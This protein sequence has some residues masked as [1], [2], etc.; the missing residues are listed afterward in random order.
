MI[1]VLTGIFGTDKLALAEDIVQDSIIEAISQW[2]YNGIPKQPIGWLYKVAKNKTLN[3]LKR[4]KYQEK[5]ISEV[6][7]N[8]NVQ[9]NFAKDSSAFFTDESISDDQLRMMFMCCHSAISNDSQ[10]ALILKTLCGFGIGEIA[11]AFFTNKES[12]NKRLVRARKKIRDDA[13]PFEVPAE[14]E[15]SDRLESVL[16]VIYLLFNEGYSASTGDDILREDL[17]KEAIRLAEML[18][19]HKSISNKTNVFALIA[20]MQLNASRFNARKDIQGNIITLENQDRSLWNYEVME[21]GFMNLEKAAQSKYISKYHILAGIS[22]LHCTAKNFAST[23]WK[24]ILS[25]YDKLLTIDSSSIVKMNRAIVLYKMGD[26]ITALFEM[27]RIEKQKSINTNYLFHAAKSEIHMQLKEKD[28]AKSALQKAFTLA[29]LE[30][31]KK[32]LNKRYQNY[33]NRN[34]EDNVPI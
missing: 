23:D 17:C 2:T 14:N 13:I 16:E 31:E 1:S 25:L 30:T 24:S 22:A 15:L 11:K 8:V 21:Q 18:A 26:S 7:S 6:L 34:I 32:M 4:R 19:T 27:Q 3:V 5:Y 33:F 9:Q 20:L 12:I 28:K 29:P 10:I